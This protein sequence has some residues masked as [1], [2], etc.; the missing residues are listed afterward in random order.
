MPADGPPRVVAVDAHGHA[1]ALG[2]RAMAHL[3]S[4]LGEHL[5]RCHR[6]GITPP[7]DLLELAAAMA[8]SIPNVRTAGRQRDQAPLAGHRQVVMTYAEAARHH[9][10]STRTLRRW[11]AQGLVRGVGRR[12]VVEVPCD[13]PAA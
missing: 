3:A 9:G 11:R 4:A 10:V 1:V 12:L 6:A 7:G 5:Q 2:D 13:L 8:P